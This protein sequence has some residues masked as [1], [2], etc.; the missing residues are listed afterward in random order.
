MQD[1]DLPKAGD[2]AVEAVADAASVVAEGNRGE[3]RRAAFLKAAH[4]VFMESGY[5]ASSMAE[6]VRRAGGSLSTLY[7]QFGDKEGL[8]QAVVDER[9]SFLTAKSG[10]A[11]HSHLPLEE[12]LQQ[13]GESLLTIV[14]SPTSVESFRLMV[15]T[16]K[17]FPDMANKYTRQIPQRIRDALA[18]YIQSRVDA[19]DLQIADSAAA[20][21]LFIDMVRTHQQINAL[22]DPTYRLSEE[23]IRATVRRAV[24]MFMGG[25]SAL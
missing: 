2:A 19:G 6:I 16:A 18:G 17:R 20:A 10:L 1:N 9:V 24:R 15:A 4:E 22:M 13:I 3:I 12:G 23:E 7:L 5:E 11:L 14:T 21:A 8:F 25:A